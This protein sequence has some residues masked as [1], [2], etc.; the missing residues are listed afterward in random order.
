[1]D[2]F[3]RRIVGFGIARDSIDGVTVCRTFNHAVA[4]HLAPV[5]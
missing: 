3:T 1:M 4:G 5:A 2:I